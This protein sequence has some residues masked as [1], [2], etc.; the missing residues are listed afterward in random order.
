[1][2]GYG[3]SAPSFSDGE[4]WTFADGERGTFHPKFRSATALDHCC[5][6]WAWRGFRPEHWCPS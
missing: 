1:L 5:R 3:V 2:L 4:I 6:L